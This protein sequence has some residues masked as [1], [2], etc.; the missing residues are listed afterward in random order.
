MPDEITPTPFEPYALTVAERG[1]YTVLEPAEST[2]HRVQEPSGQVIAVPCEDSTQPLTTEALAE[3]LEN[4]PAF[5]P[6]PGEVTQWQ[7]RRAINAA[8][9]RSAVEA[10]VAAAD[11]TT[12][13]GWEFA[14]SVRRD[15]EVLTNMAAALGLT[16]AQIDALFRT[17]AALK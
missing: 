6:V 5:A 17:A 1:T 2:A 15:N 8:G 13:D 11:Q 3:H 7:I 10:A 14:G 12:K 4:P 9:L 16:A